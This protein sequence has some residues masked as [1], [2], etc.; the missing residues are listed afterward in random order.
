MVNVAGPVLAVLGPAVAF[1]RNNGWVVGETTRCPMRATA[2][3]G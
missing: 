2:R 1:A 3:I